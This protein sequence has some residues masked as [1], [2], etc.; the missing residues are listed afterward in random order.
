MRIYTYIVNGV[1]PDYAMNDACSA[2]TGSFLEEAA[3]ESLGI[4]MEQIAEYC[5][6]RG[7]DLQTS[8]ISVPLFIS[9]DIKNAS[10][11]GIEKEDIVAG[12]VYSIAMNYNTE[13]EETGRSGTR[14]SCR[15]GS[16]IT[17]LSDGDGCFDR[18]TRSL[19]P[20]NRV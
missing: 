2:G 20:R 8:M 19:F 1:R 6:P 14:S 18:K 17:A 9:S 10:H 4:E 16:V 3:K 5:R 12:L 15:A 11:E 7:K 13:L